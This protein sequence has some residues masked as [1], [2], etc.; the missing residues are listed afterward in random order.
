MVVS[1]LTLH[2]L[3]QETLLLGGYCLSFLLI[4][5]LLEV[6]KVV[7]FLMWLDLFELWVD[8]VD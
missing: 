2:S 7:K 5:G 4:F 3:L 8:F 1:A 6:Q